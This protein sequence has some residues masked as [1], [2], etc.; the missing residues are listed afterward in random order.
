MDE[1]TRKEMERLRPTDLNF[2]C[3]D[4]SCGASK[5]WNLGFTKATEIERDRSSKLIEELEKIAMDTFSHDAL[6]S[7]GKQGTAQ[8]AIADYKKGGL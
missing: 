2:M 6:T 5:C 7:K 1:K 8:R 3:G 4:V